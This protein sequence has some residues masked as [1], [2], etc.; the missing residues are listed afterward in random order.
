MLNAYFVSTHKSCCFYPKLVSITLQVLVVAPEW[1]STNQNDYCFDA[2]ISNGRTTLQL[3]VSGWLQVI[4]WGNKV[5]NRLDMLASTTSVTVSPKLDF[6]LALTTWKFLSLS[7]KRNVFWPKP[8]KPLISRRFDFFFFTLKM[9]SSA[10]IS[11][12][13]I[14]NE[15]LINHFQCGFCVFSSGHQC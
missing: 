12:S 10:E 14:I 7:V 13:V 15:A 9:R 1:I 11:S 6:S 4:S 3:G 5:Y 2:W 8:T